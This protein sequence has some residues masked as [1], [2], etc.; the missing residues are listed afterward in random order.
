[1]DPDPYVFGPPGSGTGIICKDPD[2]STIKQNSKK[3]LDIY[4]SVPSLRVFIFE[5]LDKYLILKL[6]SKK[7]YNFLFASWRSLTT[8]AG[9]GSRSGCQWYGSTTLN[10]RNGNK[11][12]MNN[13]FHDPP[14][15]RILAYGIWK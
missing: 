1:M 11:T 12:N 8:R 3:N 7:E 13:N 6:I 4:C 10:T 5:K 15:V 14:A 2:P 9:S